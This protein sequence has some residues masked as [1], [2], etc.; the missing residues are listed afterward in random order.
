MNRYPLKTPD[1]MNDK[2]MQ[3]CLNLEQIKVNLA[4]V[5]IGANYKRVSTP[6]VEYY[7]LFCEELSGIDP[8][9]IYKFTGSDGRLLALRPD[10]T[11][12]IARL[13]A[14]KLKQEPLPL[15]LFYTENIF[16][17]N[18]KLSG[19]ADETIQSGIE[20]LGE[21]NLK[22]DIEVL[23][24]AAKSLLNCNVDEF[25]IELG[26]AKIFKQVISEISATNSEKEEIRRLVESRNIAKLKEISQQICN[27]ESAQLLCALPQTFGDIN[28]IG[29]IKRVFGAK[30]KEEIDYLESLLN[31]LAKILPNDKI[32]LD[33]GLVHRNDYYSGIVFRGFLAGCGQ[34][35]LRGGRY[36]NLLANFGKDMPA[37][38]F[39]IDVCALAKAK[40][41]KANG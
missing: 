29:E 9:Q 37:C 40:E 27:S 41:G 4:N 19:R 10:L 7:D 2:L 11:L 24:L 18:P 36:D 12:P 13:V 21:N 30:F 25:R 5:F 23:S 6:S 16:T 20:L 28:S 17:T 32:H 33:L 3:E 8:T 34:A 31:E 15:R 38:G 1:G 39:A 26:S 22:S 35:V 14:T